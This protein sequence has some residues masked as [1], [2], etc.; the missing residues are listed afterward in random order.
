[1]NDQ[2]YLQPRMLQV[3]VIASLVIVVTGYLDEFSNLRNDWIPICNFIAGLCGAFCGGV[4]IF[5]AKGFLRLVAL[6]CATTSLH[7]LLKAVQYLGWC[8]SLP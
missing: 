4:T 6:L 7:A 2:P 5:T 8:L 1:M 3:G